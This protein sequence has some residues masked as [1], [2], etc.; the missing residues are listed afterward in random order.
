MSASLSASL[1]GD[2]ARALSQM[3]DRRFLGVLGLALA[4]TI[5]LLAALSGAMAALLGLLPA[6]LTLPVIG[7]IT[8]PIGWIQGAAVGGLLVASVFLMIPV[9]AAFVTLFVDRIVAAVDDRW[10]PD[11]RGTAS[12][13]VL[14]QIG[15]AART[16]GAMVFINLLALVFLLLTGPLA[17]LLFIALNGYLLGREYFETVA[18]HYM[19]ARDAR[20]LRRRRGLTVWL[21]GMA[22]AL[23]LV[24]PVMN[25]IAPV[26]GTAAFTHLVQRH[27][28]A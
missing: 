14:E 19:P 8:T 24:I 20:Q 6:T 4:L 27:R 5:G 16:T 10:Y 22:L 11:R 17:P 21:A 26:L 25:L 13:S 3:T 1:G 23:A 12:R 15:E 28:A 7:E 18:A 2:V 9:S